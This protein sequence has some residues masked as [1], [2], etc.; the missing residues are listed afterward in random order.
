MDMEFDLEML[1]ELSEWVSQRSNQMSDAATS[2]GR[3]VPY[4][5][6]PGPPRATLLRKIAD[7]DGVPILTRRQKTLIHVRV[8]VPH[9]ADQAV[10]RYPDH[11]RG[12]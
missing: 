1:F 9:A 8:L 11:I 3:A 2:V 7:F 12:V 4:L 10:L 6:E 5:L